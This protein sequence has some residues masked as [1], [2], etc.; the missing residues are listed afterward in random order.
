MGVALLPDFPLSPQGASGGSFAA[1]GLTG[2]RAA[3]RYVHALPYERTTDRSDFR[4]VLEEGRGT[5]STKRAL[6]AE[7]AR[8]H[9]RPVELVLGVYEMSE[10]NTPGVGAVLQWY[11]LER[12]PEAHCYLSFEGRRVDLTGLGP[13]SEVRPET[14]LHEERIQPCQIGEYKVREHR[15]FVRAWARGLSLDFERVWR[16]RE[17][18]IALLAD[19]NRT[20]NRGAE[21][22][23]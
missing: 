10:S 19:R 9:D 15:E 1:R 21:P 4:L 22:C 20:Q 2:Y 11:G 12:V 5:C 17:D 3:A 18:C 14:L 7:L 13:E 6:F 23:R 16:A 8:E